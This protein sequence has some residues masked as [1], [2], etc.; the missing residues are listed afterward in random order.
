MRKVEVSALILLLILISLTSFAAEKGDFNHL[1]PQFDPEKNQVIYKEEIYKFG[2]CVV[3]DKD[4]DGIKETTICRFLYP[5]DSNKR[6]VRYTIKDINWAWGIFG[7]RED[8]SDTVIMFG[9]ID[10]EGKNGFDTKVI[11]N[12]NFSLPDWVKKEVNR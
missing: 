7:H 3:I 2:G 4:G 10:S 9:F 11:G 5:G 6:V 8:K 1:V 12:E